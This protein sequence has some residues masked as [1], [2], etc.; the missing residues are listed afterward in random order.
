MGKNNA[1][2][3]DLATLIQAGI[4]PATGLP[5]KL[6]GVDTVLKAGIKKQLR[7][8]DEQN[9]VNRYIWYN[10]PSGLT[11][12]FIERLLYYKGKLMFFYLQEVDEFYILPYALDGTIDLYGRFLSVTPVPIGSTTADEKKEAKPL[13]PGLTKKVLYEIG[14]DLKDG[15]PN[16]YC[17]LLTDYTPQ[18]AINDVTPRQQLQEPILEMMS[19]IM[20]FARTALL[21]NSGVKAWRVNDETEEANVKIAAKSIENAAL[22]GQPWIPIVSHIEFQDLTSAGSALKSEEYLL[23]LQGV[24]NY[25]LS[26]YGLKNG[27]LFQKKSHML[28]AEQDMNDGN[29]SLIY[30]DGLTIRQHFCDLVNDLFGLGIWCDVNPSMQASMIGQFGEEEQASSGESQDEGGEEDVE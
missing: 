9:A 19:D 7:I 20:P 17:V 16:D 21:A 27:G 22:I 24:D 12:Q 6:G 5:I 13:I 3:P 8:L 26:L 15:E 10:L 18:I 23:M 1:R 4:N 30:D 14:K 25:R 28:E 11:G 29:T 2:I